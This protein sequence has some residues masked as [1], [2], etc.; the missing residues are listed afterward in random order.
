MPDQQALFN[1]SQVLGLLA[2]VTFSISGVLAARRARID[3]FGVLVVGVVTALGGGT[4]R[5]IILDVPIFWIADHTFL[6]AAAIAALVT[7]FALDHLSR[8]YKLL[9]YLDAL[10]VALFASGAIVKTLDLGL[11]S[12]TAAVMGVITG[13]GGGLVRDLLT[14]RP[15]LVMSR[16][17]YATPILLGVF[18]QILLLK[19]DFVGAP[20]A[21]STGGALIFSC[22]AAAIHFHLRMPDFLTTGM[23]DTGEQS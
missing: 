19:F 1:F 10:G 3:L 15:T 12:G 9:L 14:G 2:T 8:R 23:D 6:S 18:V 22:R 13:I 21:T 5:D 20:V 7:F 11:G 16:D 4:L 17:L